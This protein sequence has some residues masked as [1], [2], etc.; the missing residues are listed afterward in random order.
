M[1]FLLLSENEFFHEIKCNGITSFMEFMRWSMCHQGWQCH[2]G[3]TTSGNGESKY[4]E[5]LIV[6][7]SIKICH[8]VDSQK[9]ENNQV[10]SLFWYL[11]LDTLTS[12]SNVF[13]EHKINDAVLLALAILLD[14]NWKIIHVFSRG[15][16]S[17][18][19]KSVKF[20]FYTLWWVLVQVNAKVL[21]HGS[22][23]II[24]CT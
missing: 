18:L 4:G 3:T 16:Q 13:H 20:L 11:F 1:H 7:L 15:L 6:C 8:N 21:E 17:H 12:K 24:T 22:E 2:T 19:L 14:G 5:I 10:L 23:R 9:L